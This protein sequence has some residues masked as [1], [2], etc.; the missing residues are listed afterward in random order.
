MASGILIVLSCIGVDCLGTVE[1]MV[2]HAIGSGF[3]A[4]AVSVASVAII[5]LFLLWFDRR[6]RL[7][8]RIPSAYLDIFKCC[9]S[10]F[11]ALFLIVSMLMA[12]EQFHRIKETKDSESDYLQTEETSLG[13]TDVVNHVPIEAAINLVPEFQDLPDDKYYRG[14]YKIGE[15]FGLDSSYGFNAEDTKVPDVPGLIYKSDYCFHFGLRCPNNR[16][17]LNYVSKRIK[18]DVCVEK[19]LPLY[20]NPASA[21]GICDYYITQCL[22]SKDSIPSVRGPVFRYGKLI[23]DCWRNRYFTTFQENSW[24]SYR[25]YSSEVVWNTVDNQTGEVLSLQDMIKE[26]GMDVFAKLVFRHLMSEEGSWISRNT[27]INSDL[28]SYLSP[29]YGYGC[30]IIEEGIVVYYPMYAMEN[31][32]YLPYNAVIPYAELEGILV[33]DFKKKLFL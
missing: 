10:T 31:G 32:T 20:E 26:S 13:Y 2:W 19:E 12:E 18:E 22:S 15:H 11:L 17:L 5:V 29:D 24:E 14:P 8:R 1:M 9:W 33:D 27:S 30:A 3:P 21:S 28:R 4:L 6:M 25:V 23:I 7:T 16:V